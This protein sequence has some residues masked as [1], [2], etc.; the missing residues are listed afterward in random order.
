MA[1]NRGK[2]L[3]PAT[4]A[5]RLSI[6]RTFFRDLQDWELIPRRLDPQRSFMTPKSLLAQIGPNPRV[7][8]DDVWAKL[9]WAGLNFSVLSVSLL[10]SSMPS[11]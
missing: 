6:L 10:N 8:A 1:K 9:V 3:G 11:W 2:P 5:A 7:I 4:K